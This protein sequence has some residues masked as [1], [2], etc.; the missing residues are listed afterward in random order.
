[1]SY[2]LIFLA[3]FLG[4]GLL[5]ARPRYYYRPPNEDR[6]VVIDDIDVGGGG[7]GCSDGG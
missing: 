7:D 2:L 6:E 3:S 5:S 4:I 1:M